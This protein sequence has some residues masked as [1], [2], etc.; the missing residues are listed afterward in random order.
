MCSRAGGW[1]HLEALLKVVVLLQEHGVVDDYLGR[2]YAQ[3]NDA[4]VHRLGGLT[5]RNDQDKRQGC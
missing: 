4:V 2:G 5:G 1:C 3:V